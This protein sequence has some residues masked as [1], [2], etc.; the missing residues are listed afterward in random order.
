MLK[1][2][3]KHKWSILN[4][5]EITSEFGW[6][7][8]VYILVCEKCGKIE[9]VEIKQLDFFMKICYNIYRKWDVAKG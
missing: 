5:T 3:C 4:K 9:K 2:F 1:C 6:Y 7:K 8:T